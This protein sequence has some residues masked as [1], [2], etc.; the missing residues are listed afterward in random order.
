MHW[1]AAKHALRYLEG[2]VDFGLDYRRSDGIRLVGFTDLD[3]AGS[4][5]DQ[6]STSECCFSLGSAAVSWFSQK[7]K[8][9]ALSSQEAKYMATN[10]ASCE[11]L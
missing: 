4:V 2:T 11:A 3:W 9:A 6:K 7:Q 1:I 8:S 10:Q 5:V